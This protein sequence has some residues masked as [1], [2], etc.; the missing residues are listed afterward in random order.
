MF[1]YKQWFT[2]NSKKLRHAAMWVDQTR[3]DDMSEKVRKSR[4]LGGNQVNG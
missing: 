3:R 2:E 4:K 1:A